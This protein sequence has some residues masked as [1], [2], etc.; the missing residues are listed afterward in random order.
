MKG[1]MTRPGN[2]IAKGITF[3]A[4]QL[5][6]TA[7]NFTDPAYGSAANAVW[8]PFSLIA[9]S[10]PFLRPDALGVSPIGAAALGLTYK[11]SMQAGG[12]LVDR[13]LQMRKGIYI[14]SPNGQMLSQMRGPRKGVVGDITQ[15]G[16]IQTIQSWGIIPSTIEGQ[17][18]QEGT[19][20]TIVQG[21]PIQKNLYTQKTPYSD[22]IFYPLDKILKDTRDLEKNKLFDINQVS[23]KISID[24]ISKLFFPQKFPGQGSSKEEALSWVADPVMAK[25]KFKTSL[26]K[27]TPDD[28]SV[29]FEGEIDGL[30]GGQIDDSKVYMPLMF[31]D[32]RETKE[33]FLYLRAFLK[34]GF[35]ETFNANWDVQSY[36]GRVDGVPIYKNTNRVISL[37]FDLLAWSPCELPIMYKKLHKLQS[38]VYPLFDSN[39]FLNCGPI[40]RMKVG[41]LISSRDKLGLPGYL[42]SLDFSYD[43]TLWSLEL[44]LKAPMKITVTLA[45]TVL[46]EF[47]PGVTKTFGS[48][49]GGD[50]L[51]FGGAKNWGE[52]VNVLEKLPGEESSFES[53]VRGIITKVKKYYEDLKASGVNI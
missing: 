29:K 16:D 27:D 52:G 31:Q 45:F 7:L 3:A 50:E 13:H 4:S 1:E 9:S 30:R 53:N 24:R 15:V 23:K 28:L 18:E 25:L 2:N 17:I 35:T 6:L 41:D 37:S 14:E 47:N 33:K 12:D 48:S 39:G 19:M 34:E 36:F 20:G 49:R 32:L 26:P 51:C 11:D 22:N 43:D 40:I 8:N 44:D 46:H 21:L 5:A 10:I 42:T 38:M